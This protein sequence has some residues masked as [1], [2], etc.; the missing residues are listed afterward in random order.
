M[1]DNTTK[2]HDS[3]ASALSAAQAEFKD[4]YR[5]STNPHF[6][7]KYA[8]L[9]STL[10]AVRPV[11]ARHGLAVVQATTYEAGTLLLVTRLLW[12]DQQIVGYYPVIPVR[13]DPQGYGSAMTY[14]RR[15]T[16]ASLLGVASDPDDDGNAA[17]ETP[18]AKAAPTVTL[19]SILADVESAATPAALKKAV[20]AA[21]VL[22]DEE[23]TALRTRYL[24]RVKELS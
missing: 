2:T 22:T 4:P 6:K 7:S 1:D 12:R 8:D 10:A 14:A 3:L 13:A 20:S 5:A 9:Q 17:S 19:A 15:Y 21:A 23:R 16:L 24:E 11:L 18:Q